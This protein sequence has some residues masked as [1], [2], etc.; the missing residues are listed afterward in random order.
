MDRSGGPLRCAAF[1][2]ELKWR[3]LSHLNERRVKPTRSGRRT[4][5]AVEMSPSYLV[6]LYKKYYLTAREYKHWRILVKL[7]VNR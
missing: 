7:S 3:P 1:N 4:P 6:V 5:G 2:P